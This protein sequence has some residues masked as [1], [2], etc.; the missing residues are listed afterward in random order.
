[1]GNQVFGQR[2]ALFAIKG[3]MQQMAQ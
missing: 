2:H 3:V 1:L